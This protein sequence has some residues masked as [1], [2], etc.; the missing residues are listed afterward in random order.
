MPDGRPLMAEVED[1][2]RLTKI[3]L[4]YEA[5]VDH[6]F[7]HGFYVSK[8]HVEDVGISIAVAEFRQ[9]VAERFVGESKTVGDA[10][11]RL[12]VSRARI[13]SLLGVR[14]VQTVR[15]RRPSYSRLNHR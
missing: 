3:I 1:I 10:G 9:A 8:E 5:L 14:D 4:G 2:V 11:L 6:I 15:P 7:D 13:Y 12:G